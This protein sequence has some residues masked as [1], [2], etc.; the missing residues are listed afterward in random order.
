MV[1]ALRGHTGEGNIVAASTATTTTQATVALSSSPGV[2]ACLQGDRPPG[3]T[4]G[5][6][7]VSAQVGEAVGYGTVPRQYGGPPQGAAV[8]R[9]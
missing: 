8:S 5:L 1:Q 9:G 7:A 3:G 4:T 6:E 2:T